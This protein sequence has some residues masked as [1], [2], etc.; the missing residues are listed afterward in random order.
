MNRKQTIW[1]VE[2]SVDNFLLNGKCK[3]KG[4]W[5]LQYIFIL[6]MIMLQH[7]TS[8]HDRESERETEKE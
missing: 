1:A 4:L 8:V 5:A 7:W 2:L 6:K 3:L